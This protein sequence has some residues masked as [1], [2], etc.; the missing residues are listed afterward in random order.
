MAKTSAGNPLRNPDPP[1]AVAA[2]LVRVYEGK[3]PDAGKTMSLQPAYDAAWLLLKGRIEIESQ[4]RHFVVT[5]GTCALL[6]P[7]ERI[8]SLGADT[9]LISVNFVWADS[10]G[11]AILDSKAPVL[12]RENDDPVFADAFRKFSSLIMETC[13][14]PAQMQPAARFPLAVYHRVQGAF[15]QWLG[16]VA[17]AIGRCG[18]TP[19]KRR[20]MDPRIAA[21]RDRLNSIPLDQ[22]PDYER[23]AQACGISRPHAERLFRFEFEISPH[24]Y[25]QRRRFAYACRLL[26]GGSDPIKS[27][28]GDLGFTSLAAFSTWFSSR[29]HHSPR[30]YRTLAGAQDTGPDGIPQQIQADRG[31]LRTP[32]G[33]LKHL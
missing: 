19:G 12:F 26:N 16:E 15:H 24:G 17:A 7:G 25:F 28:A 18:G 29:E 13:G 23:L 2:S 32:P 8:Q 27:I 22:S 11:R 21:L 5:K 14:N 4:G 3:S 1:Q 9:R 10:E 6:G 31:S 33:A 30:Q 20:E